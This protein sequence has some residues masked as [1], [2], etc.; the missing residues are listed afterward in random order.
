MNMV[1]KIYTTVTGTPENMPMYLELTAD[2]MN[3]D[4]NTNDLLN[5]K[6]KPVKNSDIESD[7][8][9]NLKTWKTIHSDWNT[10]FE[11]QREIPQAKY[12]EQSRFLEHVIEQLR[13]WFDKADVKYPKFTRKYFT[14]SPEYSSVTKHGINYPLTKP[15]AAI[16]QVLYL[17]HMHRTEHLLSREIFHQA[18]EYLSPDGDENS[19]ES[20]KISDI[21]KSNKKAYASLIKRDGQS[22][23][24]L[25]LD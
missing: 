25:N 19:I 8:D 17:A 21:F 7:V 5:F 3:R 13:L 10:L 24:R 2:Y 11:N 4:Y 18:N 15:Q 23:Y 6:Q 16:I 12:V 14:F 9:E 22:H 20:D 1:Y